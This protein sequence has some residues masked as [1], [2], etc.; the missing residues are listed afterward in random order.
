MHVLLKDKDHERVHGMITDELSFLHD[1][2][3]SS[4]PIHY[5]NFWLPIVNI[6]ISLL[7][8]SHCLLLAGMGGY[9]SS[10]QDLG[11]VNCKLICYIRNSNGAI[12][13]KGISMPYGNLVYDVVPVAILLVLVV[14]AEAR[15]IASYICSNWTKVAI[16]SSC[17]VN[18][19]DAWQR[20]PRMQKWT[21][22]VL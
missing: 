19:H 12:D 22:R 15:E 8:I 10:V 4:I 13:A 18:N 11:Q 14:L 1:Y 16:F 2:Y 9:I 3:Y 5:S 20:S 6:C 7:T 17:V 21:G